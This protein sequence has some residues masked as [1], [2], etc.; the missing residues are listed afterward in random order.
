MEEQKKQSRTFTGIVVSSAMA[1][2]IVVR[3]DRTKVHPKYK[4]RYTSSRKYLVHDE[5]NASK[6]GQIVSFVE[7][8]PLSRHKRWRVLETKA[9]V[10][11]NA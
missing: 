6:V 3:V 5:K 10:T 11:G 2:T 7:T 8:R 4:K 9:R 1:K